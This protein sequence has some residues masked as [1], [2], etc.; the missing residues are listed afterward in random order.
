MSPRLNCWEF[1]NCGREK[2]GLMVAT[3]GECPVASAMHCDGL[4]NGMAAGRSCWTVNGTGHRFNRVEKVT[5]N[6]CHVCEFY[7]RVV[8]EEKHAACFK[9]ATA[10]S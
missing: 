6:S 4:N 9:F 7:K 8:N 5:V 10:Q 1:K 2:G 3:L